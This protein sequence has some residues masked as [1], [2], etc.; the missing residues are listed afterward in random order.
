MTIKPFGIN[1]AIIPRRII[2]PPIPRK[3]EIV[4]LKNAAIIKM[5]ISNILPKADTND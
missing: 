5:I 1:N 4:E 2:P 3:A